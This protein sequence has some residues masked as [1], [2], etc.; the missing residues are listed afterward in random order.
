MSYIMIIYLGTRRKA[1]IRMVFRDMKIDNCIEKI[2][3][4]ESLDFVVSAKA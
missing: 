4:R 2:K 3:T 1:G